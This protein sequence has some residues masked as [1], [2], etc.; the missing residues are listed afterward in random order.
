MLSSYEY[1]FTF[2]SSR[3]ANAVNPAGCINPSVIN[4]ETRRGFT[5]LQILL[6]LRGEN[7]IE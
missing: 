2:F 1:N 3:P 4:S 7:R 6:A 5:W